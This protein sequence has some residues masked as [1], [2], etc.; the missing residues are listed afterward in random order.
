M[1]E[2]CGKTRKPILKDGFDQ[3]TICESKMIIFM[4]TSYD[5]YGRSIMRHINYCPIC[6]RKL[7]EDE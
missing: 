3:I 5:G 4:S 1:C 6:G 2:Y 7:T